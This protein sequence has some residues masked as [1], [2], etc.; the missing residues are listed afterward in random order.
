MTATEETPMTEMH[1]HL[2]GFGL[3]RWLFGMAGTRHAMV[4]TMIA[5]FADNVLVGSNC[6]QMKPTRLWLYTQIDSQKKM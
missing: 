3:G 6:M 5:G 2:C 1:R 4:N